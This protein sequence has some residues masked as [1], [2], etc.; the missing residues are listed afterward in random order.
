[1]N[2]QYINNY[3]DI[4]KIFFTSKLSKI[5][6]PVQQ[7]KQKRTKYDETSFQS[8]T[9][10]TIKMTP[11]TSVTPMTK[12]ILDT[13]TPISREKM[14]KAIIEDD[15]ER[16]IIEMKEEEKDTDYEEEV[17]AS[18]LG[19]YME[20]YVSN[21]I[22]CPVCHK[23]TLL[24]F[25]KNNIPVIDLICINKDEHIVNDKYKCFIF[26]LKTS[27]SGK[28]FNKETHFL[29]IGSKKYGYICHN[30]KGNDIINKKIIVPGYICL[31]V[32]K[33]ENNEYNIN[34]SKSFSIVPKYD[35]NNDSF[36]FTYAN[37]INEYTRGKLY[38]K[39]YINWTND[40]FIENNIQFIDNKYEKINKY[41]AFDYVDDDNIYRNMFKSGGGKWIKKIRRPI[42]NLFI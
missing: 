29:T 7:T 2:N 11:I 5:V 36:Y 1:M 21:Y 19:F 15:K 27:I 12:A 38:K 28:Y 24:K 23:N 41:I 18:E 26:Q 20:D 25:T 33:N 31:K 37:E 34:M 8:P 22:L 10:T 13:Q 14:Y 42:I 4:Y 3:N 40:M 39:N 9:K 16:Q 30:V 6:P 35:I 17:L 32:D